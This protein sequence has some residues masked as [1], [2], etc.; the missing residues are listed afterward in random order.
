MKKT[1]KLTIL[2]FFLGAA[3]AVFGQQNAVDLD[4][5]VAAVAENP[6]NV[7]SLVEEAVSSAPGQIT[8]ITD[9]L[10]AEFPELTE[11]IIFGAIAGM[12]EVTEEAVERLLIH[13]VNFRP[14]LAPEIVL[15]ARNATTP[16]ME[17]TITNAVTLA[18]QQVVRDGNLGPIGRTS[19][20]STAGSDYDP[21]SKVISPSANP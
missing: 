11:G 17:S 16:A 7:A 15:G 4:A 5:L 12:P 9:R 14:A 10:M 2:A 18:L 8:E 20:P 21:D 6:E 3:A 13:A 1:L 19:Q